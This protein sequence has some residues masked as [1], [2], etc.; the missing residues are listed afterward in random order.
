MLGAPVASAAFLCSA[1]AG[2]TTFKASSSPA[3]AA[4]SGILED[5]FSCV[6]DLSLLMPADRFFGSPSAS[7]ADANAAAGA[8][9]WDMLVA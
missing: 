5:S 8:L 2:F 4:E 3:G 6:M 1:A 7:K 9:P